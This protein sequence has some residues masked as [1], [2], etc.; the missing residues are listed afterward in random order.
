MC[1]FRGL[2]PVVWIVSFWLLCWGF[3][4]VCLLELGRCVF[5]GLCVISLLSGGIAFGALV[6]FSSFLVYFVFNFFVSLSALFICGWIL[7]D[8]VVVG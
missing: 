8:S 3:A 2:C 7:A 4:R 1:V 6:W 5:F